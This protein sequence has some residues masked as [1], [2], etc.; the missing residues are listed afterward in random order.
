MIYPDALQFLGQVR[1][2]GM[3]LGLHNMRALAEQLG[4]PQDRL[5]FIHIAGTN[6]KGSTAAFCA[7]VLQEAGYRTGLYTSPHLVDLGERIQINREPMAPEEIAEGI[8]LI[9][10]LIEAVEQQPGGSA[11]TF[12]E[13]MTALALWQFARRNVEIVVWETGLG[14]RLDATNIV[15]PEV[16]VITSVALDHMEY[17]GGRLGQIAYEKAGIIKPGVPVVH[18]E[19]APE[20]LE[21]ITAAALQAGARQ[22]SIGLDIPVED[23][24]IRGFSQYAHIGGTEYRLGLL[25][26]HQAGNAACAVAALNALDPR[27]FSFPASVMETGL[28]QAFWPGRFQLWKQNPP[29]ILDG[30]HNPE[31]VAA[32]LRTWDAVFPG[33]KFHLV[34][35][36][37]SDK[38]PAAM[39]PPLRARAERVT[40][41]RVANER[42]GNPA[43]WAGYFE[44]LPVQIC[45]SWTA[46]APE[47]L[48][49]PV[50]VLITG[51]LFLAGEVLA[52]EQG[53][54]VR[55]LNE[56]L[57][58]R[59]QP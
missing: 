5:K 36:V 23:R 25:G 51:S 16:S 42:S 10:P 56:L 34:W 24:E 1:R 29:V 54:A 21:V 40:L 17:L 38:N 8:S 31:A 47:V 28:A 19:L 52:W 15:T 12:F 27:R 49:S 7:S 30:A 59:R 55:P 46:A 39:A 32:L 35:G 43:D 37:L 58:A 4:N 6:G 26:A 48:R 41:V 57:G 9:K 2:F 45:D 14:G 3:K 18:G 53:T 33:V 20:A 22:I 13:V 44:G 11:P 50:P